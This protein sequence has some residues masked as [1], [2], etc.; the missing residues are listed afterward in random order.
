MHKKKKKKLYLIH[1]SHSPS[2]REMCILHRSPI[3]PLALALNLTYLTSSLENV[4]RKPTLYKL[5]T[6]RNSNL[7]SIFHR[8]GRWSKESDQV[9]VCF[10]F[11]YKFI[12]PHVQP[13]SWWCTPWCLST[14]AYSIYSQLPSM[15]GGHSSIRNS[16]TRH[17][18]VIGTHLTCTLWNLV[19]IFNLDWSL[20]YH[21]TPDCFN[22]CNHIKSHQTGYVN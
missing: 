17:V 4:I 12:L 2:H 5:L 16:R 7:I 6:F 14:A 8:L 20:S 15:V 21:N 9:R 19:I 22:V 11:C 18:V 1:D 10:I 3:W 13:L